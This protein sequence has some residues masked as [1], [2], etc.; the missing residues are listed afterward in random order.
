MHKY[1]TTFLEGVLDKQR[2]IQKMPA[3]ILPG[4]VIYLKYFVFETSLKSWL[5]ASKCL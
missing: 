1:F 3:Q 5:Y 4:H 2:C